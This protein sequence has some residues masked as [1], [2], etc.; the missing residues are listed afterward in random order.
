[1]LEAYA[2]GVNSGV[3]SLSKL[4]VEYRLLNKGFDAWEVKDGLALGFLQSW[5]LETN[6][7]R[8][9]AAL[10]MRE[11]WDVSTLDRLYRLRPEEPEVDPY[12]D[13]LRGVEIG[14]LTRAYRSWTSAFGGRPDKAQASNNWVLGP[15]R[16]A[17][18]HAIVANDP[19]LNQSV[20][21]LWYVVDLVGGDHRA[22]GATLPGLPG[23]PIGHNGK[24][25]WG[26]TNVMADVVDYA[27]LE[28]VG[29]RGYVLAGET[30]ELETL[31][32]IHI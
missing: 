7:S 23:V 27:V 14:E 11:E 3:G 29:D 28:R 22:A 13:E 1:M 6:S 25:A 2:E 30:L 12:W 18:G 5:N 16:T 8:E 15:D 31:S 10:L 32:L 21:S 24:V 4:P 9:M 26:L 20:P 17:S 19:H